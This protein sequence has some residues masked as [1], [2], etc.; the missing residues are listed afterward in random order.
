MSIVHRAGLICGL[1]AVLCGTAAASHIVISSVVGTGSWN[2]DPTCSGQFA[3]SHAIDDVITEPTQTGY[4]LGR[5][6]TANET[7]TFNLGAVYLIG[8]FD[9]YNTHNAGF[10]DRGSH[11]FQIWISS[12]PVTPD[13]T[14]PSFGTLVVSDVL[15]FIPFESPTSAQTFSITP[16]SGQYV[17]FRAVTYYTLGAGL[18]EF[19]VNDA[20]AVPEPGTSALL[21]AGLAAGGVRLRLRRRH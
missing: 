4:W 8:G 5:E 16:V 17:T 18:S 9:L 7:L 13:T 11:D 10:N 2:N 12:T 3:C 6:T 15:G 20:P 21:L 19:R 1:A 14:S